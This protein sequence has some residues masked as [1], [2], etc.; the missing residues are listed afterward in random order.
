MV[1]DNILIRGTVPEDISY[2]RNNLRDTDI[3]EIYDITGKNPKE[4]MDYSY[5]VSTKSWTLLKGEEPIFSWG[6][7]PK[8]FLS[9]TG[10]AW[11]LGS[12]KIREVKMKL[13]R[14][15]KKYIKE[16]LDGY[17]RLEGYVSND[18]KLS[19]DWLKWCGFT[20]ETAKPT[21]FNKKMFHRFYM[22]K[23]A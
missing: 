18:N 9:T 16:M 7:A 8:S 4:G 14:D 19:K 21:G 22:D 23:E 17:I 20:L 13:L 3:K 5:D 15:S 6:V 1:K 10:L 2:L 12:V 11:L